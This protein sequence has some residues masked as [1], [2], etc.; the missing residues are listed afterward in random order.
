LKPC[1]RPAF[2][3]I[4]SMEDNATLTS[5]TVAVDN[6]V[7]SAAQLLELQKFAELGRLSACL[8][9]EISNP[10]TAAMLQLEQFEE[11]TPALRQAQ[12]SLRQMRRYIESARQQLRQQSPSHPFNVSTQIDQLL[13]VVRPVARQAGAN[14]IVESIPNCQLQGDPIK[15]QQV[16][17]NL[18]V[19]AIDAYRDES[20]DGQIKMVRLSLT[21]N[22]RWLTVRVVDW[23]SGITVE[24]LE[25]LF[26][27]FYSTKTETGYG[28][29]L[30]LAIVHQYVTM[31]F[32]GS[33]SATSTLRQ[34]TQFVAKF[35]LSKSN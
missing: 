5:A 10:L 31:D 30:G 13:R 6:S 33:V 34:G 12:R 16:I 28:L 7:L 32:H 26:K 11:P 14:L 19:N 15:F 23:G 29:G 24:Q 8:L 2:R 9:H 1:N 21:V 35:R 27:P 20:Y 3:K 17:T 22:N 18:I 25:H 4:N